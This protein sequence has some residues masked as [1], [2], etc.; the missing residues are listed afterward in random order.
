MQRYIHC[1]LYKSI[2]METIIIMKYKRSNKQ[3][4]VYPCT[5]IL[6]EVYKDVSNIVK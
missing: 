4:M 5:G 1:K 3:M 6:N 2:N